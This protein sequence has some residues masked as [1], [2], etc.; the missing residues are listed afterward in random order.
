M[1]ELDDEPTISAAV[2]TRGLQWLGYPERMKKT[3]RN[4][5]AWVAAEGKSKKG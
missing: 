4:G 1:Y 5:I 2:G 3:G